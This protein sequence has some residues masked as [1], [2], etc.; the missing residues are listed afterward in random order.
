MAQKYRILMDG[1]TIESGYFSPSD[2]MMLEHKVE[3]FKKRVKEG[4][5]VELI[6]WSPNR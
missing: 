1:T 5:I 2:Y 3:F 4:V 6:T